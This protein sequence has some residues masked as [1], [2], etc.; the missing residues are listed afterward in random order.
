MIN[1]VKNRLLALYHDQRA[2]WIILLVGVV[3]LLSY[4]LGSIRVWQSVVFPSTSTVTIPT[5]N[6]VTEKIPLE[7]IAQWHLMGIGTPQQLP[8]TVLALTLNGVL[9]SS[10]K[11]DSLAIISAMGQAQ[12]VYGVGE[13]LPNGAILY[14]VLTDAVIIRN[15][16]QLEQLPL[17][18]PRLSMAAERPS[19]WGNK[20]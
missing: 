18:R 19:T 8:K 3:C 17:A 15:N 12:K 10:N 9:L 2:A 1:V 20:S 7:K 13:R 5:S 14:D 16:D 4:L 6:T 11:Q